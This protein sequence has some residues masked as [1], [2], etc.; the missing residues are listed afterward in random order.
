MTRSH[1]KKFFLSILLP[2]ILAIT[3]FIVSIFIL[4]LPTFERNSMERKKE[5]IS[6]L[7]N[8]VW[9]LTEEYNKEYESGNLTLNE[10]KQKAAFR[11]E[12]IR[13]GRE[14]K[15]Y[16]WIIDEQPVMVMHPY[17]SDL[18]NTNLST[19]ADPNGKKL[20]V[21]AV[22]IVKEHEAG[23][24]DYMWQWKDD[25]TRIVPK[26]SYVKKY[27]PWGWIIGTGIYL[28]D[29]RLE[30]ATLKNK[31]LRVSLFII[32]IIVAII[33]YIIRQSLNI[34]NKREKAEMDL[35]LS[36]Q[37][38]KSLV[39]ASTEGTLMI[40]NNNIIFSNLKF[41][42]LIGYEVH[43]I[44]IR[45]FEDLFSI[46]W[47]EVLN[48]FSDPDK[49]IS[50]ETNILCENDKTKEV[51]ISV[52]KIKYDTDDGYI[53]I[54]KEVS[55][56]KLLEKETESLTQELQSS[57]MLMNQPIYCFVEPIL[58]C[59]LETPV[60]EAAKLMSRK[61]RNVLFIQREAEIVGVINNSDM[62]KRV[63]SEQLDTNKPVMEIM[64]APVVTVSENALLYEAVLLLKS[65]EISHLAVKT[66]QGEINS[67]IGY[68]DITRMQYN[69]VSYLIKE[70]E[71]AEEIDTIQRIHTRVPVLVN[72][73]IESGDKT[74]NI[75]RIITSVSDAIVRRILDLAIEE[76]GTPPAK[77]AFMVM[78]SE[79]RM[80][81]TLSTDQ[82]NAIVFENLADN[83]LDIAYR[84]F[85]E[86]GN[87][88]NKNL[89]IVGYRLCKGYVMA[90]NPK[91]TQPLSVWK[92]YFSGYTAGSDP[93]SIMEACIFFD[94]RGVYGNLELI[95]EL[96][97]HVIEA[98]EKK[99]VF[100]YHMAQSVIKYKIPVNIFGNIVGDNQGPEENRVDVKKV[101]MPVIGFIRLYALFNNVTETN[102]LARLKQL[103]R[104]KV[105]QKDMYIELKQSYSFLMQQRFRMQ[106]K[107]ILRNESP[108]NLVNVSGFT[109]I[110]LASFK[111]I[112]SE[113]SNL[114]TKCSFD[115]KGGM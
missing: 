47:Q 31:L 19:Y 73:L 75:T 90:Q 43:E 20:F 79:G 86:L 32:V 102:S 88:V 100:Y 55:P 96:R 59:S 35:V 14:Y 37:K 45:R 89:D 91:W 68:E 38:Y 70:I 64:T 46:A 49:S 10:A 78:G 97:E 94:F 52:S 22:L 107:Q 8:T 13:Y 25:S 7:T 15:D 113:I 60:H 111:K 69:T 72:A 53:I 99:P 80:E 16:F 57:L 114:Q 54:A 58:K 106:A 42:K 104:L 1:L 51:I 115:F 21:E 30:I 87:I 61:K 48:A 40:L 29:V 77:F 101:L 65:K 27:Q 5:M 95:T 17:R 67:V 34:E 56:Q 9:S 110:E 39:E 6:E 36:R 93:Q 3:M 12:Q 84:Y 82:D 92:E 4:V 112:L 109:H 108:D 11:I 76:L 33:M 98:T 83:A 24:I 2:A 18:I 50:L 41:S 26:L 63:V 66:V 28:E 81:Q 71:I 44:L 23:F 85:H 62:R 74:A 105:I 103:Y